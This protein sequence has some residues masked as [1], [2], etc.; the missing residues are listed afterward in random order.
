M[1]QQIQAEIISEF[2]F[3]DNWE[4]K[5]Q[6]IIDLGKSLPA[7]P[8]DFKTEEFKVHGC[9][10]NVWLYPKLQNDTVHFFADSDA[11]ITK[12][13]IALILKVVQD[14]SPKEIKNTD[15][16]FIETIGLKEHLSP[17]RANGLS[18]MI[19]KIKST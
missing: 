17:T 3:F 1:T 7:M 13:L 6:H 15:F 5:Y 10:S 8:E 11:I 16:N 14:K 9:Q 4:D 18:A 2:E 19:E 12:G